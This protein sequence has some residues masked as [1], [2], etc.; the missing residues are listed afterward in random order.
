MVENII[1]HKKQSFYR[2]VSPGTQAEVVFKKYLDS[3]VT[4]EGRV[5]DVVETTRNGRRIAYID[6][7]SPKIVAHFDPALTFMMQS[8]HD[9]LGVE[10][11]TFQA[12]P[13]EGLEP[14]AT[15]IL[16]CLVHPSRYNSDLLCI[17]HDSATITPAG[18]LRKLL[19][20]LL[21]D[22]EIAEW[23][24][25]QLASALQ[26]FEQTVHATIAM[27]FLETSDKTGKSRIKMAAFK[28]KQQIATMMVWVAKINRL[29]DD[30]K[31]DDGSINVAL[32][33]KAAFQM[34][35]HFRISEEFYAFVRG[36]APAELQQLHYVKP[37]FEI[38]K[39]N[40]LQVFETTKE[41]ISAM[42]A[43]SVDE[44]EPSGEDELVTLA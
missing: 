29:F 3:F 38:N 17:S 23:K 16:H 37:L 42:Q 30:A 15:I 40:A 6:I 32:F 22:A 14:G 20:Q 44:I 24:G 43:Q 1:R 33:T 27:P 41:F 9:D 10:I 13:A 25:S 4:V 35:D 2:S 19:K 36:K 8:A 12:S 26:K 11:A 39:T 28:T 7:Q 5:V 21:I 31:N 18:L 34:Q